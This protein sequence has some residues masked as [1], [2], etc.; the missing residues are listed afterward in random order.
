MLIRR[1]I[2]LA[3]A[4][5]LLGGC[6]STSKDTAP[7][8]TTAAVTIKT[9]YGEAV[10]KQKPQRVVALGLADVAVANALGAN[11]VGAVKNYT[12][13]QL[14]YL[15]KKL[16]ESVY[17]IDADA[18]S[19]EK[20][21]SLKPDLILA[22]SSYALDKGKYD[23]M[24]KIAPVVT[25]PQ[26]LYSTP[27]EED[28]LTIGRA[29]GEDEAARRLIAEATASITKLK[30]ELPNLSGK[31]YLYGQARGDVLPMVVG[32]DNQSTKF[33]AQLGLKVPDTFAE[34]KTTA[35]LAPGTIG[36]S[37]ENADKLDSADVLFMTF[38]GPEDRQRFDSNP[39][40][41]D[42]RVIKEGRYQATTIQTAQ[43]LQAPD[44][45]SVHWLIDQLKPTLAKIGS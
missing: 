5:A 18:P 1:V 37:Y 44:I 33:M 14:P 17:S 39:L 28:A 8:G 15:R 26:A 19:M 40:T 38:A 7:S 35:E 31:T 30:T 16:D 29:V 24:S 21:A 45:V 12:G 41:K 43:A 22:T 27:M 11:I 25:Y 42:L 4:A 32:K 9:A 36:L 3:T 34:A 6:A 10:I 23:T 20:I 13:E 2:T